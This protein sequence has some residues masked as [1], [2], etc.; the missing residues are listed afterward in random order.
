MIDDRLEE[1][2]ISLPEPPA[3]A[4]SYAPVAVSG[5]CARV[6]G[7]LPVEGGVLR[8]R[9]RVTDANVGEARLSARLCAVNVL[10]QLR[11]ELGSLDR[12]SRITRVCGFVNA[13][14]EF[15]AHPRVVD[16]ASDLFYELFG[17]RGRHSRVA[18]G[19]SGLPLGAMTEVAADA[20]VS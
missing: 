7:Q 20:E 1:L 18:V 2:G 14:P 12:V 16:A 11:A 9:G 13:G 5:G 4:G 10:A 3:P 8:H 6:S 19:A 15:G 17:E